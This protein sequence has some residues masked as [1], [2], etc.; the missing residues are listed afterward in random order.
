MMSI[1]ERQ[2]TAYHGDIEKALNKK[3]SELKTEDVLKLFP[4]DLWSDP[5]IDSDIKITVSKPSWQ[6]ET[7]LTQ[8]LNR[9]W[10]YPLYTLIIG[11]AMW[12]CTGYFGV[13]RESKIGA[14]LNKLVGE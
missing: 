12:I 1:F 9:L 14:L 4:K 3:I 5:E 2:H 7:T 11:P 6:H 13:Y 10:V 8:R